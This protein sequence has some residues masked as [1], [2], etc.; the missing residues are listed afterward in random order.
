MAQSHMAPETILTSAIKKVDVGVVETIKKYI[1]GDLKGG[2]NLIYSIE[3]D[4]VG[5]EKTDILSNEAIKY[6]EDKLNK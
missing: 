4:G 3:N 5:Y 2:T 6:V 1:N